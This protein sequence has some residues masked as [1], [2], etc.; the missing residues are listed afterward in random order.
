MVVTDTAL[1]P[2]PA[3]DVA[4]EQLHFAAELDGDLFTVTARGHDVGV[5]G[6]AHLVRAVHAASNRQLIV[7][8]PR[9]GLNVA[10]VASMDDPHGDPLGVIAAMLSIHERATLV[11]SPATLTRRQRRLLGQLP[12]DPD[13]LVIP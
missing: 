13:P 5:E 1:A 3:K 12:E 9:L 2:A 11:D 8:L 10:H 4:T 7:P 6:P